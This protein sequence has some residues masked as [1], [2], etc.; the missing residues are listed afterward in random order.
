MGLFQVMP[1]HFGAGEDPFDPDTNA[2]RGLKYLRQAL[3]QARGDVARALA[4]YNGGPI[5]LSLSP[6]AWPAE[7]Q[8]YVTWGSGIYADAQAGR[9]ESP[10]LRRWLAAG[11]RSLCRQARERLALP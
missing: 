4:M 7:T 11:G 5:T 3:R 10:T 9:T 8:R 1:Y 2:H 6:S